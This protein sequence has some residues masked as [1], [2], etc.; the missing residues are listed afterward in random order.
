MQIKVE[1]MKEMEDGSAIVWLEMDSESKDFF[2]GEGF[3]A[4]L[5]RSIESS[6]SYFKESENVKPAR[7]TKTSSSKQQGEKRRNA[8]GNSQKN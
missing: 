1:K 6:E 8:K 3:L 7:K 4:V 5:K 2:I